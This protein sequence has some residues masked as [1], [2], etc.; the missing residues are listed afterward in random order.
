M[1]VLGQRIFSSISPFELHFHLYHRL[2]MTACKTKN[3]MSLTTL[4][5]KIKNTS[6]GDT[7]PLN[8]GHML[9]SVWRDTDSETRIAQ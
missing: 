5:V 9:L 8:V 4:L 7:L 1:Y 6:P 3:H 2:V